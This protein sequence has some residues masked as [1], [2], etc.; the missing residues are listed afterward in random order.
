MQHFKHN[1][2]IPTK[3]YLNLTVCGIN[4]VDECLHALCRCPTRTPP[5]RIN[6]YPYEWEYLALELQLSGVTL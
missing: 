2:I 6:E 1:Y 3:T 4:R 5:R